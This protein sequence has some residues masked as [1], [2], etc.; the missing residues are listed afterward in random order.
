LIKNRDIAFEFCEVKRINQ[1]SIGFALDTNNE[2]EHAEDK[3]QHKNFDMVLLNSMNDAGATFEHDTIKVTILKKNNSIHRFPI[4]HK[5][6]V[7]K[8]II[9][10]AGAIILQKKF[11]SVERTY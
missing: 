1:L 6:E 2:M 4:K 10:E 8:D 9:M 11:Y 5:T 3:L 7:A